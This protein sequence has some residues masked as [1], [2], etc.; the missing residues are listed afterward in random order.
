MKREL[1]VAPRAADRIERVTAWL[2]A[3]ARDGE[4]LVVGATLEAA[5]HAIRAVV[6]ERSAVFGWYRETLPMLAWRLAAPAIASRGAALIGGLAR[7]ALCA[8]A[9][10]IARD[11]GKLSSFEEVADRPGFPRALARTIRELELAD[12]DHEA[13]ASSSPELA[14]LLAHYRRELDAASLVDRADVYREAAAVVRAADDA[15]VGLPLVLVDVAVPSRLEADLVAGLAGAAREVIATVPSGDARSE[16]ELKAALQLEVT[17]SPAPQRGAAGGDAL[18]RV[19]LHLFGGAPV[20]AALD[21]TV[22]LISTPGE[23]REAV[24]IVRGVL[25]EAERGVAFDQMAVLLRA[26][27]QYGDHLVEAFARG[28]VP[29]HFADGTV[30]PDPTGRALLAL[31]ACKAERLSASRF[32]EYLSLGVVPRLGSSGEPP[33]AAPAGERF[34]PPVHDMLSP[35]EDDA[36][37]SEG[38]ALRVPRRW[39]KLLVDAAVIGRDRERWAR[40]LTGL[41]QELELRRDE[42]TH[43]HPARARFERKLAEL[44]GLSQFALPLIDELVALPDAA[45][46]GRWIDLLSRLATRALDKPARV[47]ELFAELLP[48]ADVGPVTLDE[49]QLV[50][51]RRLSEL[52]SRPAKARAGKVLIAAAEEARGLSFA[53]VFVP[54]LAEKLFPKKVNEDPLALDAL[55]RTLSSAM[56]TNSVR[57]EAERLALR[58]A[59]GAARQ[60]VVLSYPRMD[61]ERSRPRVPSFYGL[62]L[63]RAAEGTLPGFGELAQRAEL[64]AAERMGWPAPT[65]A[66]DAIDESEF[67]MAVLD[68]YLT[69]GAETSRKRGAAHYLL[70]QNRHL[71]RA[72]RFRARRWKPRWTRN[73]GLFRP[74][75][76]ARAA[77]A[78][79][80]LSARAYSP[81]ALERF[82]ACPYQFF[83]RSIQKLAPR[84]AV[85]ATEELDALQRG[86]LIHDVIFAL[87]RDLRASSSLPV[88][89]DNLDH[90][91][92][93]LDMILRYIAD[94]YRERLVP[95]ISR[96]WTDAIEEI[97][98]DLL[99]WLTRQ[100]TDADGWTPISF[101]LGFGLAGR[102]IEHDQA[103]VAEPVELGSG[104]S[105]CGS[106]DLVEQKGAL[107]RATDH[108]TGSMRVDDSAVVDGGRML[109]P[110]LYALCLE[111]LYTQ[112]KVAS[113]RLHFCTSRGEFKSKDVVLDEQA[114]VA[115]ERVIHTIGQAIDEATLLALPAEGACRDCEYAIVCGPREEMHTKP[116]PRL[117]LL[118]D[119]R[120]E[121]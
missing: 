37:S 8:R 110:L 105:L 28:H 109:Q 16:N 76:R 85:A 113:G 39:E 96:V 99:E 81:T 27:E 67:D 62:E 68:D 100:A 25:A 106:I 17:T 58:L 63:L 1:I 34:R 12:I 102:R 20:A 61:L 44:R 64:G 82:A 24:E 119:L 78:E 21:D 30:R 48:M 95:A 40:R 94:D 71:A 38:D 26:P 90:C 77:L 13:L 70:H 43:D 107:L 97:G 53:V 49:V 60:K 51:A 19:Q 57:V 11:E 89:R 84:Q 92:S 2:A 93:R 10:K 73:D 79:H 86:R 66:Q 45:T 50:L 35:T 59:V 14:A 69:F 47:L 3:R 88:T 54:G 9:I 114:R 108:K 112:R 117:P 115:I 23:S 116:K 29:A 91:R 98:G 41:S 5:N 4:L 80:A 87:L 56:E 72:L 6:K 31:L 15:V 111:Q 75:E 120:S 65:D 7:H 103:S 18:R 101:E 46:W 74:N 22:Q 121:R 33:D 32:A 83:L 118:A 42:L 104:V 55:R 36:D 52:V